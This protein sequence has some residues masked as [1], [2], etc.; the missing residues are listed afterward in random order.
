MELS[1]EGSARARVSP[2]PRGVP[3]ISAPV[4]RGVSFGEKFPFGIARGTMGYAVMCVS[5]CTIS[6]SAVDSSV[7][8]EMRGK[9]VGK[10]MLS[11][12]AN[13]AKERKCGR[14]EW[15]VLDWNESAIKFYRSIGAIPMEEWTVQRVTGEALEILAGEFRHT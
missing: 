2:P 1:G 10:V 5:I 6:G 11:Y 9:G 3:G 14:L 4:G 15:W 12:L 13:L 7:K 8:P